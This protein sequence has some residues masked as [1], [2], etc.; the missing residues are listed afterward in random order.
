M[1]KS[2]DKVT[3]WCYQGIG[4][5]DVRNGTLIAIEGDRATIQERGRKTSI[6][7]KWIFETWKQK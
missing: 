2:G 1:M 6:N 5:G 3:Y 7:V 4:E